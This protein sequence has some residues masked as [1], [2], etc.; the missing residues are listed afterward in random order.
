MRLL[1]SAMF[2]L[3]LATVSFA[4]E[5][6]KSENGCVVKEPIKPAVFIS[7]ESATAADKD[8]TKTLLRLHNNTS[9]NIVVETS[10]IVPLPEYRHLFKTQTTTRANGDTATLY[11]PN[12]PEGAFVPIFYDKQTD[13]T[14]KPKPANYWEGR[15]LVNEYTIPGGRSVI[16]AVD[17]TFFR[18]R[19]RLSV[20][21]T[22]EWEHASELHTFGTTE[23]RVYYEYELPTGYYVPN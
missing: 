13:R 19:V 9:C 8:K 14:H 3:L 22:Y 2:L 12:P 20:P 18:K 23:H 15:D 5:D 6:S 17:A 7:F 10:D 16:F 4:Q 21:F 11:I 1:V